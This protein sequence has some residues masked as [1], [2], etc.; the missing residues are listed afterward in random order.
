[1]LGSNLA[2]RSQ[3]LHLKLGS[4]VWWRFPSGTLGSTDGYQLAVLI[5]KEINLAFT[6]V[7]VVSSF[8]ASSDEDK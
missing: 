2:G 7:L 1:M 3:S 4:S 6:I 5:I 8:L